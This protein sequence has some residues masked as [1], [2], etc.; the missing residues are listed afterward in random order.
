MLSET[1]L[2]KILTE[3]YLL[4]VLT[5]KPR[6]HIFTVQRHIESEVFFWYDLLQKSYLE[7]ER[8]YI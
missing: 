6:E 7:W 4:F 3:E 1:T 5:Q 8:K 2:S